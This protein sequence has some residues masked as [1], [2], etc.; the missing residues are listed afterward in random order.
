MRKSYEERVGTSL[1]SIDLKTL[2]TA[3]KDRFNDGIIFCKP[4]LACNSKTS[5]YVP[6]SESTIIPNPIHTFVTGEGIASCLQFKSIALTILEK[7]KHTQRTPGLSHLKAII[8]SS[9]T[10]NKV[11]FSFIA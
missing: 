10:F 4:T 2:K 7:C 1:R 6:S 5:G 11:L 8:E 9:K 3:M